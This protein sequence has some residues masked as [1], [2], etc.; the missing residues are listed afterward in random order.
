MFL[1]HGCKEDKKPETHP[2]Q[3]QR[4]SLKSQN[5]E[6]VEMPHK[7]TDT[8]NTETNT[9]SRNLYGRELRRQE[10][11]QVPGKDFVISCLLSCAG[12]SIVREWFDRNESASSQ[13]KDNEGNSTW[14]Y[15]ILRAVSI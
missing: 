15:F 10:G 14:A 12:Q 1:T 11:A 4:P 3:I 8:E 2:N 9:K 13:R 7:D 5:K 6:S